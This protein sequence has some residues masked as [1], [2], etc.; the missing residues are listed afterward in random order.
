M[1]NRVPQFRLRSLAGLAL[2]SG[3][4]LIVWVVVVMGIA[5]LTHADHPACAHNASG[6]EVA[7][8]KP[9]DR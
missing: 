7:H 9:G 2:V 3:F 8:C 1:S 5:S 4:S 6:T